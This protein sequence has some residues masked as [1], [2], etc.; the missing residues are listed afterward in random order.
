MQTLEVCA[1]A[2]VW[3]EEAKKFNKNSIHFSIPQHWLT[4][5]AS[6]KGW[7]DHFSSNST[8]GKSFEGEKDYY[9]N[10]KELLAVCYILK[11]L[12]AGQLQVSVL[13]KSDNS[14]KVSNINKYGE[15]KPNLFNDITR[16][17]FSWTIPR[18]IKLVEANE[19]RKQML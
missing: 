9:I 10:A 4:T 1:V 5:D 12:C 11:V 19:A 16:K 2:E 8:S 15:S 7:G 17:T 3:K 18:N 13:V 14:I 6:N